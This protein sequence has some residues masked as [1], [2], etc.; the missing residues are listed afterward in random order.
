MQKTNLDLCANIKF[1]MKMRGVKTGAALY[2]KLYPKKNYSRLCPKERNTRTRDIRRLINGER[3]VSLTE[4]KRIAEV[5]DVS[6][7][8]LGFW[9]KEKFQRKY[10]TGPDEQKLLVDLAKRF[11]LMTEEQATEV[12]KTNP[13]LLQR[14]IREEKRKWLPTYIRGNTQ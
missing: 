13:G 2:R 8:H 14:K 4:I 10:G 9:S 5:L 12:Y 3:I 6:P 1:A 11:C 7:E